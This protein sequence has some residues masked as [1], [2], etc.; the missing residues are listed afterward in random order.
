PPTIAEA[1]ESQGRV[2]MRYVDA[3]GQ[4]TDRLVRPLRVHARQGNLY[5]I[6]HCYRRDQLRTFRLDRVVEMVLED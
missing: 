1:L 6:A 3:W 5:L 4:E 2:R